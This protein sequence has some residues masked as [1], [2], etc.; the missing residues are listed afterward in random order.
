MS[1]DE[2]GQGGAMVE[3]IVGEH[4][5]WTWAIP[6]GELGEQGLCCG[7][8]SITGAR[9]EDPDLSRGQPDQARGSMANVHD[10]DLGRQG[11]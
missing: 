11:S 10:V 9:V 5:I 3:I 1:G 8:K 4:V 2:L 6:L 7:S